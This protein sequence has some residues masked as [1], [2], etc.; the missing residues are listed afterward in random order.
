MK[1]P[2]LAFLAFLA[3][4]S[5]ALPTR[6]IA[7]TEPTFSQIIIF[8][9]SLSDTG[10]V[11]H[12]AE[13]DYAISY[14][15]ESFGY[16]SGRFTDGK[17]TNPAATLYVGVWHEQLAK[18]FLSLG[19]VSPS[20]DGGTNYAFGG[21]TTEDGSTTR[22]LFSVGDPFGGGPTFSVDNIGRQINQ[23]N[24]SHTA[25]ANALYV[26]WGGGN[27]L[28]DNKSAENITAIATRVNGLVL[29]LA[30]AGARKILVPNLPPLG[31]VPN[32][33]GD[34]PTAVAFDAASASYRVQ[35][36]AALDAAVATLAGQ[37]ITLQLYRVDVW[38]MSLRIAADPAAYGFTDVVHSSQGQ[39]VNPDT[40]LFWDGLHPTTAGHHQISIE[41]NRTLTGAAQPPGKALNVSTRVEVGTGENVSIAGFIVTGRESKRVIIRGLGPSLSASVS[42]VLADPTISL[43]DSSSNLLATN[44]NWRQTQE[45]E[46]IATG[47]PPT[48]DLESAIVR[49]LP[50][51]NYTAVVSGT[52]GG[53]GIGLAEVYDLTSGNSAALDNVSTRGFV[54][55]G[56]QVMIAGFIVGSGGDAIV[57]ARGLGPSLTSAGILNPLADPV[58]ELHDA[59][60]AIVVANDNWKDTQ[61]P[62][63]RASGLNPSD[64]LE[65]AVVASVPP[66]NYTAVLQGKSGATGVG[67]V[68]VYRI[69]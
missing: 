22:S 50:P 1:T 58:L 38:S 24:G 21:A 66:G 7:Q 19:L 56:D 68:E 43:Y 18:N 63:I 13:S 41:A 59:N 34:F 49:T 36:N 52:N 48:N 62:A 5:A 61:L 35:L 57:V 11:K 9:D 3:L 10:N 12:R 31:E 29:R 45:A 51:G 6:A 47:V 39:S 42:G 23:Y 60:G 54:G 4:N 17:N 16:T 44:D 14:P 25:D 46:I 53:T 20:L 64:D 26:V 27:D 30:N 33:S 37:G 67:L 15:S 2:Y 69:H 32:K 55:T 40:Y 8:G 65:A 28:L